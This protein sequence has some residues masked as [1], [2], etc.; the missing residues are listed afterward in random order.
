MI[1]IVLVGVENQ[2]N[3]GAVARVM[4]NFGLQELLLVKPACQIGKEALDRASHAKSILLRSKRAD[5]LEVLKNF[6]YSVGTTSKLGTDYNIH[7]SPLTPEQVSGAIPKNKRVALVFGRESSGLTN[8]DLELCDMVVTIPSSKKYPALNLSHACA[9]LLYELSK[10]HLGAESKVG[11]HIVAAAEVD[12]EQ[13]LKMV[14]GML[15][16]LDF[17]TPQKKETQRVLWKRVIGKSFLTRREA[18]ALM[19][20]FRK[21]L[22]RIKR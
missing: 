18:F 12:K 7:R 19:G 16:E 11:M 15:G 22:A 2:G 20:F 21:A 13:I 5:S 9:I 8:D 10:K 1:S 6:D 17:S 14:D 3:L 4:A